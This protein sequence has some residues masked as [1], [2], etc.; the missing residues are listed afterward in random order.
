MRGS[1][2]KPAQMN[3]A[4]DCRWLPVVTGLGFSCF[5]ELRGIPHGQAELG[6]DFVELGDFR[7]GEEQS[8]GFVR[9]FAC[10]GFDLSGQ[11]RVVVAVAE[12]V[13]QNGLEV[14]DLAAA[15][16]ESAARDG[17]RVDDLEIEDRG[18]LFTVGFELPAAQGWQRSADEAAEE[19]R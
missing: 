4:G 2:A 15:L 3:R 9:A 16:G 17:V 7:R 6:V 8:A 10:C 12:D 13:F 18:V 11:H 1:R 14:L 5:G 19:F